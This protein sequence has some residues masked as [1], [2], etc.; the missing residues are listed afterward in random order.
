MAFRLINSEDI[1]LLTPGEFGSD[2]DVLIESLLIPAAGKRFA[3]Y[4]NRPESA[5]GAKDYWDKIARTEFYSPVVNQQII[6]VAHPPLAASPAPTVHVSTDIPR[7][8]GAAELLTVDEDYHVFQNEGRI[9]REGAY[10]PCGTKTTRIGYTG[11]FLTEHAQ[12]TP[13]DLRFAC[14]LYVKTLYKNRDLFG[15]TNRSLEGASVSV[16]WPL[17]SKDIRENLDPYVV[18]R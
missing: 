11:G 10:F 12:G 2:H 13:D 3:E 1:K 17:M 5:P 18:Y 16:M 14:A 7:V 6:K 4:C 8:Y 9:V 15:V